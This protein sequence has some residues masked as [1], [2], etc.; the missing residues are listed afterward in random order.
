MNDF[1][2]DDV[3]VG[4]HQLEGGDRNRKCN[5]C[6]ICCSGFCSGLKDVLTFLLSHIGLMSIVVAYC[7][8]GGLVFEK[9][10]KENELKVR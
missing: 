9:I 3:I 2:P 1:L 8:L 5:D 10:E 4:D 6:R 7:L